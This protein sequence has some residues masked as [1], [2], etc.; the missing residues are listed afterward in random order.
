MVDLNLE[1]SYSDR[2]PK[3]GVRSYLCKLHLP[4]ST[5]SHMLQQSGVL[6][7]CGEKIVVCGTKN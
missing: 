1:N 7:V 4:D 2:W 3:G 5:Y 6:V